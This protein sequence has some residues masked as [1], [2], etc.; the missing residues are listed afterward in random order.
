M[1]TFTRYIGNDYSGAKTPTSSLKGLRVYLAESTAPPFE[2]LPPPTIKKYWS[3]RGVAEWLVEL[4]KEDSPTLIGI[5]HGF[6]FPLRYFEAHSLQHDWPAFLEDFQ[7]HWPTD[8]DRNRVDFIRHSLCGNGAAREGNTSW[9]RLTEQRAGGAKS[10]FHFDVPGS[11]A[12]STHTGIPWLR[13]IRQHVGARVHF[14]P[15]DG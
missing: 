5:D 1:T 4:L 10:V 12:K 3:R 2:V 8:E 13:Y 14:W 9:R 7:H 15:F 6:S 11:V